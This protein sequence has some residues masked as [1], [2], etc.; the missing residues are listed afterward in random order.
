MLIKKNNIKVSIFILC[1]NEEILLPHTIAHY[2][3]NLPT[4]DI[5]IY[6]NEST[7]NSVAIATRL[8]CKIISFK[9]GN[10]IDDF[11]YVKIKD[12]CWKGAEGWVL[13]IDMDEWLCVTEE[14]LYNEESTILRVKGLQM[15]GESTSEDLSDIDLHSINKY[16]EYKMENKSLCFLSNSIDEINYSVGAHKANP[17]GRVIYSQRVYINKHMSMLGLPFL[18]QKMKKRYE[19]SEIIRSIGLATHY[20]DNASKVEEEYKLLLKQSIILD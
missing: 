16:V 15:I 12:N 1:Y 2:R 18:I 7:D 13:V 9:S 11:I 19:R 10:R 3:K 8:G 17:I 5:T 14:D 4:C 6:D 20:T